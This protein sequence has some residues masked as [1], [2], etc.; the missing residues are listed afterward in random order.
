M[1]WTADTPLE[2]SLAG[3]LVLA[4]DDDL[5]TV[6]LTAAMLRLC[7]ATVKTARSAAEALA[8]LATWKPDLVL[9]DLEMP[10][11]DGYELADARSLVP[12]K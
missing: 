5:D 7:G 3:V 1:G 11:G 4:V 9:S 2:T 8:I 10:D 6:E 12:R